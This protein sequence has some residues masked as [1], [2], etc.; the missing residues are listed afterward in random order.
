MKDLGMYYLASEKTVSGHNGVSLVRDKVA[1]F[2]LSNG[3]MIAKIHWAPPGKTTPSETVGGGGLM[4]S[5]RYEP[6]HLAERKTAYK[7]EGVIAVEP[8]FQ[9]EYTLKINGL[10]SPSAQIDGTTAQVSPTA[11]SAVARRF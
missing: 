3:A 7:T 2:H 4:A 9:Q 6:E 1:N 5:Y 10:K 8:K 11:S